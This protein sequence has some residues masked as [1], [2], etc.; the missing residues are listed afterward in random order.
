LPHLYTGNELLRPTTSSRSYGTAGFEAVE[1][2]TLEK[3]VW[4][5]V[6]RLMMEVEE[7]GV[8]T[9]VIPGWARVKLLCVE[10]N[11]D[12]RTALVH[13]NRGTS[14]HS[15]GIMDSSAIGG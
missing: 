13:C 10:V 3:C 11:L 8:E 4:Y 15:H 12:D 5:D 14:A 9:D 7:D 6:A 1:R 2:G